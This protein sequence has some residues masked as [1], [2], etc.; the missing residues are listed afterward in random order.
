[1]EEINP[2]QNGF[3]MNSK[4]QHPKGTKE[5]RTVQS[6]IRNITEQDRH[7]TAK[8]Y[9]CTPRVN[10]ELHNRKSGEDRQEAVKPVKQKREQTRQTPKLM[11]TLGKRM[12]SIN[13]SE[14]WGECIN[15]IQYSQ[16]TKIINNTE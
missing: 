8:E 1:M 14:K 3:K 7:N 6:A 10:Q 2:I 12:Q 4:Q 5:T 15:K 11:L 16:H 13:N 9:T